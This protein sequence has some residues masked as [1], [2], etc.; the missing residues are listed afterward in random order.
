M[1]E[2][3]LR[4]LVTHLILSAA[5]ALAIAIVPLSARGANGRTWRIHATLAAVVVT[6]MTLHAYRVVLRDVIP[7]WQIALAYSIYFLVPLFCA[8]LAARYVA[9]IAKRARWTLTALLTALV[10][11][12]GVIGAFQVAGGLLPDVAVTTK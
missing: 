2:I 1:I 8:G 3:V 5:L 10:L 6:A 9:K 4:N 12:G 7:L 11:V